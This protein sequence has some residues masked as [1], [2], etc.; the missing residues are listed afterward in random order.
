MLTRRQLLSFSSTLPAINL[1]RT[2][3][4]SASTATLSLI[5]L[6]SN[7]SRYHQK[8]IRTF[9]YLNYNGIDRALGL[10]LTSDDAENALSV[11]SV[12][13]LIA[14]DKARKE[15]LLKKLVIVEGMFNQPS[16]DDLGENGYITEIV[17]VELWG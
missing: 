10:Y 9:G 13:A 17:R 3:E 4:R 12:S 11:N 15:G 2:D 16:S 6:I 14:E 8:R 7:P 1:F 5:K